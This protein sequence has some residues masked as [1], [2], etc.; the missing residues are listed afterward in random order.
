MWTIKR[1]PLELWS[2]KLDSGLQY[3]FEKKEGKHGFN[4]MKSA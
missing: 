4:F 3:K 1:K 2:E